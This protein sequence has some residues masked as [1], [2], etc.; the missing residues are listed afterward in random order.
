MVSEMI[1]HVD[2]QQGNDRKIN[3]W[4]REEYGEQGKKI[5]RGE[6][7]EQNYYLKINLLDLQR[8]GEE[9][10]EEIISG[11][12]ALTHA[13][14]CKPWQSAAIRLGRLDTLASDPNIRITLFIIE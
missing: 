13:F 5:E 7:R 9:E 8:G 12:D 14:I 11:Y 6:E 10:K 1:L 4:T 3:V 2:Q